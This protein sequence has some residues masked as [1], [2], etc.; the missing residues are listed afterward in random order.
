MLHHWHAKMD[1]KILG[2]KWQNKNNQRTKF[3]AFLEHANSNIHWHL[4]VKLHEPA[5]D[6]FEAEA[7]AAWVSLVDSG[8]VLIKRTDVDEAANETFCGYASKGAK[9]YL[10]PE[11][12]VISKR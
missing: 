7:S 8:D 4:M 12:M 2:S 9:P 3:V 10:P 6:V 5:H 1:R 11:F